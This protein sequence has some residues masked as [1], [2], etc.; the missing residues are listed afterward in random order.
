MPAGSVP[1]PDPD[2][3]PNLDLWNGSS[4][5]AFWPSYS[6]QSPF[7]TRCNAAYAEYLGWSRSTELFNSFYVP[8]CPEISNF[9]VSPRRV[10]G[11]RTVY[12]QSFKGQLANGRRKESVSYWAHDSRELRHA[13]E[14]YCQQY[15][16]ILELDSPPSQP[17]QVYISASTRDDRFQ[18]ASK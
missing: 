5:G 16:L 3:S 2:R 6:P 11:L 17:G 7:C 9:P 12:S 8:L 4:H 10:K 13:A 14:S 15:D 1:D 18:S